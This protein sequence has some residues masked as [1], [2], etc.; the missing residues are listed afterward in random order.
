LSD[1]VFPQ[2]CVVGS[3]GDCARVLAEGTEIPVEGIF[4]SLLTF[5]G[6]IAEGQLSFAHRFFCS[7]RLYTV[8][9]GQSASSKKSSSVKAARDHVVDQMPEFGKL[10][11]CEGVGSGEGLLNVLAEFKNTVLIYD[12]ILTLFQKMKIESSS[13]LGGLNTL[14]EHHR[15]ENKLKDKRVTEKVENAN[16]SLLG[17]TTDDSFGRL[18]TKEQ[19]DLGLPNRLFIVNMARKPRQADPPFC[20]QQELNAARHR[21][22]LQLASLPKHF[23]FSPEGR[24]LWSEWYTNLPDIAEVR[25]LDNIGLRLL[26]ILVLTT[27]RKEADEEIVRTL[28]K[29]LDYALRVRQ[30]YQPLEANSKY[31]ECEQEVMN[32]L[33]RSGPLSYRNLQQ[34]A[35][36]SRHGT[37]MFKKVLRE[38][39]ADGQ[40][41][42]VGKIYKAL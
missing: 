5:T 22:G 1:L 9:V 10:K 3:L 42:S 30:A 35:H 17:C 2:D 23:E 38:L 27:D 26:P 34:F 29:I 19:I 8:L 33:R 4:A 16:L 12:E 21:L 37:D 41:S 6:A 20:N 13:L 39:E 18:M 32:V 24:R 15:W 7:T 28:L 40:V 25:R 11:S 14:Y 31:A 36:G